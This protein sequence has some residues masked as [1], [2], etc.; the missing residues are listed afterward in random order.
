MGWYL[1]KSISFGGLRL[2]F[3]KSGIGFSAG[4]KGLRFGIGP[5][6]SYIH[7]GSNGLYCRQSLREKSKIDSESFESNY[8]VNNIEIF[9]DEESSD[10]IL[11]VKKN[12]RKFVF[13]PLAFV[14]CFIPT[15]GIGIAF[16]TAIILYILFD[17]KIKKVPLLYDFQKGYSDWENALKELTQCSQ[18]SYIIDDETTLWQKKVTLQ[19]TPPRDIDTNVTVLQMK[20]G[21]TKLYFFPD[22]LLIYDGRKICGINYRNMLFDHHNLV[23]PLDGEIPSDGTVVG[24]TWLHTRQDGFP[25]KRYSFNPKLPELKY[26]IISF[27][28]N[29]GLSEQKIMFSKPDTGRLLVNIINFTF[30]KTDTGNQKQLRIFLDE[31]KL[32]EAKEIIKNEE[33]V[34]TSFLQ[35]RLKIGYNQTSEIVDILIE[36]NELKPDKDNEYRVVNSKHVKT[37][38]NLDIN[39]FYPSD[40]T[41]EDLRDIFPLIERYI[42]P[43]EDDILKYACVVIILDCK[44]SISHLQ[45]RLNIDCNKAAEI[46]NLL[47]DRKIIKP[48]LHSED[49]WDILIFD[50]LEIG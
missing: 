1:R 36:Q 23:I 31:K 26:S 27:S 30:C 24:Y 29:T 22:R 45:Q 21:K 4:M 40:V 15:V 2:N 50:G 5:R 13:F 19:F 17:R 43:N 9:S 32:E 33:Y 39:R 38:T 48:S 14:F 7:A 12:R 6:G 3:S 49:E 16:V 42:Q 46:L 35:R 25:D 28:S 10:I 47:E 41:E 18:A 44:A 37:F 8:S 20:I 34:N 11:K